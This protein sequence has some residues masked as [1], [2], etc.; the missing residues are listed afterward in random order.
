MPRPRPVTW[1]LLGVLIFSAIEL[2]AIFGALNL[3]DLPFSLPRSYFLVRS[4]AWSA[5]GLLG[6]LALLRRFFWAPLGLLIGSYSIALW[7]WLERLLF[8][9]SDHE[10]QSRPLAAVV[11]LLLLVS[12]TLT[13][14]H[15]TVRDYFAGR[16]S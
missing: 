3:P 4:S 6:A 7:Y 5:L 16:V 10:L 9:R 14:R 13:L 8:A 11:T 2:S 1:L 15:R 12:V